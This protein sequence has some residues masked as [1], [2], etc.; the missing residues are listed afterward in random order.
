AAEEAE[1]RRLLT[2]AIVGAG[3]TGVEMAGAIAEIARQTLA[4]D[5]RN[6]D[7]KASRIVLIEAG[8]RVLPALPPHLSDY[9]QR[10]LT[11]KGV[12]VMTSTRV[13]GVDP[14]GVDLANGRIDAATIIWAAGVVASPAARWLDAAHDR[15]GRIEVGPDLSVLG[16]PEVFALGDTAVLA[17]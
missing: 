5:F 16:H 8:T 3:A 11:Q 10:T 9:V 13:V 14:R 6:I 4:M 15:A 2:F 7:P 12:E 17:G 1:R